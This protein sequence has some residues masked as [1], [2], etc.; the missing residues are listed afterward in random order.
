MRQF[1]KITIIGVGLIG[2]SIGLA[3]KKQHLAKEVMGVFRRKS[4]IKKA[5]KRKAVDTA[6]MNIREGVKDAD[7]IVLASPVYTIPVLALEAIRYARP[8]A[9]ITD[10]GSTK[11]WL[12]K[13]IERSLGRGRKR[14][15][16][17]GSH[18]MAGSDH[19]SVEFAR[20]DLMQGS[21]C[22]V[23]K[24]GKTDPEALAKIVGFWKALGAKVA[25]MSPESH[26]RAVSLVSHLP[27]IVAFS[28]AGVVPPA[29]LRYAAEGFRD[30]TRVAASDPK[31]W[32]DI[33]LT[34]RR[35][36][37]KACRMFESY[38]KS[39]LKSLSSGDYSKTVKI[40]KKAKLNRDKFIYERQA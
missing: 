12:V 7:L 23:T 24:T 16:F 39:L 1:N 20:S 14:I 40:L 28:V 3:V 27:H 36:I 18:P 19:A 4:T 35:E 21:P 25:V 37:L 38:Y 11:A 31:L 9:I 33:F 8:C 32:A 30:T 2:G 29:M 13:R 15:S 17:V 10:V 22:I 6:T 26:D 5:L 34:N